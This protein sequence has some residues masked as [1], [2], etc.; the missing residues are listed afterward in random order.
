MFSLKHIKKLYKH[1]KDM[2]FSFPDEVQVKSLAWM[3]R[4]YNGIGAEWL[5]RWVRKM[6]TF[7]LSPLEPAALLHDVEYLGKNK[8]Y[9][10]FTVANFRLFLNAAKDKYF[11]LGLGAALVCQLFGWSAWK[12]GKE[13]MCYYYYY[14]EEC[15]DK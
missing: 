10:R 4:H 7:F 1:A 5:P 2:G 9:W 15:N 14:E 13:T 6:T 12:E 8:S 3:R 11:F